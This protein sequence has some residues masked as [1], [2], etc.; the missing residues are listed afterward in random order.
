MEVREARQVDV[1]LSSTGTFNDMADNDPQETFGTAIETLRFHGIR[2]LHRVE[3][4]Q[5]NTS[6]TGAEKQLLAS[7]RN[8][9]HGFYFINGNHHGNRGE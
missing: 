5:D 9:W 2:Y 3:L 7:L 1:G 4:S 6:M 8:Q